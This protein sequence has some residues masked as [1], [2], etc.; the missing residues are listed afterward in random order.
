MLKKKMLRDIK[1]NPSGFITIFL[2]VMI[3]VLAY[4]GIE[5]YMGG[6]QKSGDRFYNDY[7]LQDMNVVGEF[8]EKD[9]NEIKK[10]NGVSDA[11]GKLELT[12]SSG[13]KTILLS[14]I[15]ENSVSKFYTLE[16]EEFSHKEGIWLDNYYARENNI[17]VG[18]T[19]E[20]KYSNQ[21]IK[22]KVLGLIYVPDHV[23]DVK[24]E[25]ELFPNKKEFGFAY[26][27]INNFP[28]LRYSSIMV[29]LNGKSDFTAVKE[30]ISK[31]S[32]VLGVIDIKNTSS[33][34]TYQGEIDE[35]KSYVGI[36]S[37]LFLFI[38]ILSVITT[39]TRVIKRERTIIG[40]L[41]S[42]GYSDLRIILHYASYGFIVSLIGSIV[43]IIIGYYGIGNIF[44]NM[45]MTYFEVPNGSPILDLTSLIV[46]LLVVIIITLVTVLTSLSIL[47][48][49]PADTLKPPV[50]KV[51]K[52]TLNITT[53]GIFKKMSFST[54]WNLRD[55]LRNK[56]RTLM[57][58]VGITSSCALIVCALGMFNSI[59]Y[60]IKLQ[61]KD[62]Y[63]FDYKLD[64]SPNITSKEYSDLTSK[65]GDATSESLGIEILL[66]DKY[67]TNNL[68]VTDAKNY[69]RF[70]NEKDEFIE[71]DSTQG[72]YITRK[73]ASEN[74][75][76]VGDSIKWK[77]YGS[78]KVIESK[79]VGLNKDPQN[80]NMTITRGYLEKIGF[81]YKPDSLYTNEDLSN[82]K[83]IDGIDLIKSVSKL[84]SG[85]NNMLNTMKTMIVLII[86]IA[87]VLGSVIIYS[88]G[89][90][91]LAEKTYQ[92]AALEVLGFSDKLVK[93]IFSKQNNWILIISLIIGLPLGYI[94]ANYLFTNAIE[95]HYDFSANIENITYV[96]SALGTF[97]ISYLT[98]KVLS[99][100]IS[101]IDMVSSLKGSE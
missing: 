13:E 41:K 61:F 63:N 46:A 99:K 45:E 15:S 25:S 3:G 94:L 98:V 33:Y 51:N 19:I 11:N 1:K 69:V 39:M 101:N 32:N 95:A 81:N 27:D 93:K 21:T 78:D 2:M 67:E 30:E 55:I 82:V 29:K 40:I 92:F 5:A 83:S 68:F 12:A 43:G 74:N 85:M 7:N 28:N 64:I 44:I 59:N 47:K 62:L 14:L 16:G 88:M 52:N 96:I 72:V 79:I 60:F 53:K 49:K 76:K 86:F 100:K 89:A 8:T 66:N 54:K 23:Y 57:G 42:L 24:D 10:I 37:G 97:L 9:V 84:E 22:V 17:K 90:L 73:L 26:M 48:E 58:I 87:A 34:R 20:L 71:L 38:A 56:A 80:Q 50:P 70:V 31:S 35:G 4:T 6:M 77:I 36:F 91:S 18:D 65:Y 75:L